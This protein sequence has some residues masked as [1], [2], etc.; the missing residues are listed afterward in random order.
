METSA[1]KAAAHNRGRAE[2]LNFPRFPK[3]LITRGE[4]RT[5]SAADAGKLCNGP[6]RSPTG[7]Q[8]GPQPGTSGEGRSRG[9][10]QNL[11]P[12]IVTG[13]ADVDPALVLT[14]TVAGSLYGYSLLWVVLCASHS[15]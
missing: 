2:E 11:V 4:P 8:G 5:G 15:C 12:G 14:A 3:G 9:F 13:A 6:P 1:A 7:Q 10:W